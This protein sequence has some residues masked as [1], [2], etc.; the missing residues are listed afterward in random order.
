MDMAKDDDAFRHAVEMLLER[1]GGLVEH[2][3]DPGG[4]TRFGISLRFLKGVRPDATE[5]DIRRLAR[6]EAVALYRRHFWDAFRLGELG[7]ELAA[8]MLMAC[9][10]VGPFSAIVC[11][12]RAIRAVTCQQM[13]KEDGRMGPLTIASAWRV[14][15]DFLLVALRAELAGHYRLLVARDSGLAVFLNGWLARAYS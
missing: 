2:P 10:N 12:Q 11:L 3:A 8:K 5:N 15:Q 9:V 4:I 14:P 7:D 6:D 13:V 1:E